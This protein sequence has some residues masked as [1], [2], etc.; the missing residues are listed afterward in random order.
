MSDPNY[1]PKELPSIIEPGEGGTTGDQPEN[2]PSVSGA[3]YHL[4]TGNYINQLASEFND[5]KNNS[6]HKAAHEHLNK[7]AQ[8]MMT[9]IHAHGLGDYDAAIE[10]F[11][12][13][14][15]R[16]EAADQVGNAETP[17]LLSGKQ[18]T[19]RV[20]LGEYKRMYGRQR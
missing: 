5:T 2:L 18:N 16:V 11:H 17:E 12:S 3:E 7:A 1:D 9:S 10:H 19:A 20:A 15:L 13:A 6:A 14:V 4:A 8:S